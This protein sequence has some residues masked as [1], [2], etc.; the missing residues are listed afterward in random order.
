MSARYDALRLLMAQ[1]DLPDL[2]PRRRQITQAGLPLDQRERIKRN[3]ATAYVAYRMEE[4]G[5][6]AEGIVSH[7]RP[8][9]HLVR[10]LA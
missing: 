10:R 5:R 7:H 4:A 3:L 8:T 1:P 6:S 9:L 2:R